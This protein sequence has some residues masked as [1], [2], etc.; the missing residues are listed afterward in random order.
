MS[1]EEVKL[2]VLIAHAYCTNRCIKEILKYKIFINTF[3]YFFVFPIT[4][5]DSYIYLDLVTCK[6]KMKQTFAQYS[7]YKIY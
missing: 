5:N 2:N 7:M 4:F 3:D 6:V 1:R